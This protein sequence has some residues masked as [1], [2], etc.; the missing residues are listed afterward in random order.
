MG[1]WLI[2]AEGSWIAPTAG[3]Y[4]AF[5]TAHQRTFDNTGVDHV[6]FILP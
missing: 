6:T 5:V 1:R 3:I 4:E 2:H